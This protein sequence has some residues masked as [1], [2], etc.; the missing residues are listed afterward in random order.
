[1][2]TG[3]N[4]YA[5]PTTVQSGLLIVGSDGEVPNNTSL[6]LGDAA[7]EGG[8]FD[9]NGHNLTVTGLTTVGT[10][11]NNLTS[12][13]AGTLTLTYN[14]VSAADTFN[15]NITNG[16]A[17]SISL[18]VNS[19]NLSLGGGNN[20][21]GTTKV[22]NTAKLFVN[23]SHFGGGAYTVASGATLGGVRFHRCRRNGGERGNIRRMPPVD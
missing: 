6:I 21:T 22:N 17:Q 12:N 5:G 1:M 13:S 19:G 11:N 18:V 23:G 8:T 3:T 14:G 15:A 4:T 10:G 7:N 2:L 20:Y 9:L 16:S